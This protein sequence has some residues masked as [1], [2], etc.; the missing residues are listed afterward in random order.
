MV[1]SVCSQE[2][3]GGPQVYQWKVLPFVLAA[4]PRVFTEFL[5][6]LSRH[7]FPLSLLFGVQPCEVDHSLSG[8]VPF[9]M[10]DRHGQGDS[11]PVSWLEMIMHATQELLSHHGVWSTPVSGDI[12]VG[13][14]PFLGS[15]VHVS[16][17]DSLQ[18]AAH[19]S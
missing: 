13:I 9:R 15:T 7:Q 4:T 8:N 5:A 19:T 16:L 12:S 17:V 2:C 18:H 1:P 14:L 11:N 6:P 10:H 3:G